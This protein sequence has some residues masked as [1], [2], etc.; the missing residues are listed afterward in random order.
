M[1]QINV[2]D[3]VTTMKPEPM[4]V[5]FLMAAYAEFDNRIPLGQKEIGEIL[6]IDNP[7]VS[8]SI[9]YLKEAGYIV[10]VPSISRGKTYMLSP[11]FCWKGTTIGHRATLQ[12]HREMSKGEL[13]VIEGG[14]SKE[15]QSKRSA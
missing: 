15:P 9:K 2:V 3:V 10:E 12:Q 5:L 13:R 1:N 11:E 14:R 4:R 6:K 8:K 7:R